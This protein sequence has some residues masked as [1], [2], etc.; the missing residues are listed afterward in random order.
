MSDLNLLLDF[1]KVVVITTFNQL[2]WL[3]GLLVLFGLLLY[4]FARFTRLTYIQSVGHKMDIFVTG[5]IGT[6]V[7]ELGHALFCVIFRHRIIEM[8]LFSPN[9]SDGSLG[10]V[11]HAYNPRNI[12]QRIGN[13]FIGTGPIIFGSLVL[14]ALLYYLVP[15]KDSI[16]QHIHQH[17]QS[18]VNGELPHQKNM[19]G[20]IWGTTSITLIEL[21][22]PLNYGDYKFWIFI[23]LAVSVASHMELSP[24]DIKGALGGF[25]SLVIFFLFLNAFILGLELSDTSHSMGNWLSYIKLESYSLHINKWLGVFGALFVF[26]TIISCINFIVTYITLS[27]YNI[28]RGRGLINPAWI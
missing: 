26:A 19:L 4:I 15:N 10:Y 21:F 14:Y 7:H 8:K 6:P 18:I 27:L 25:I 12:Y 28:L 1:I 17:I 13:F 2:I 16:F 20:M 24:P 5:W 23:Y 9:S 22:H 11:H 3:L